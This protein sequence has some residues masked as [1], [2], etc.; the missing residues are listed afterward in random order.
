M[1]RHQVWR[2]ED[3]WHQSGFSHYAILGMELRISGLVAVLDSFRST[4][5]KL[6]SPERREA[7]L[8]KQ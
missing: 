1:P 5:H 6:K 8:R 7:Q 3:N 4:W 2:S